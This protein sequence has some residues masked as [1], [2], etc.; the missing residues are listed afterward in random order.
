MRDVYKRQSQELIEFEHLSH[1]VSE[2][3]LIDKSQWGHVKIQVSADGD[4][5]KVYKQTVTDEDFLGSYYQLE[6]QIIPGANSIHTGEIILEK[7]CIRDRKEM[8]LSFARTV[9]EQILAR[10]D[11]FIFLIMIRI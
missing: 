9:G 6:Y 4:F 1:T 10:M 11:F 3:L 7:M 8:G 5:I 2:R